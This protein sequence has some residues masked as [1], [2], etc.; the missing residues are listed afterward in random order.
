MATVTSVNS[1]S[2]GGGGLRGSLRY[3]SQDKKTLLEEKLK[4]VSGVNCSPDTAFTEFM[5]TKRSFGKTGG[6]Q[7]Y[8]FV[9]SFHPNESVTPE[10][11]HRIGLELAEKRFPGFEVVVATHMDTEYLHSHL[12]V[13]SVSYETGKKLHQSAEDLR[14]HRAVSDE[15]RLAHGL[16]ILPPTPTSGQSNG[17]QQREY[18][19]AVKGESWKFRLMNAIDYCMTRSR[20]RREFIENMRRMEYG[21][22]WSDTRKHIT[23]TC[24]SGMKCRDNRLHDTKYLKENMQNEFAYRQIERTEPSGITEAG[25]T[26]S[27]GGLCGSAGAMGGHDELAWEQPSPADGN[28]GG[29]TT[30]RQRTERQREIESDPI[31]AVGDGATG[32]EESRRELETSEGDGAGT[33]ETDGRHLLETPHLVDR[34]LHL[35]GDIAGLARNLG[36]MS[37]AP[38]AGPKPKTVHERKQAIGQKQDDHEQEQT[39]EMTM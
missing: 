34:G 16:S 22:S 3:I 26:L 5:T 25:Q 7:F 28:G 11:V 20:S 17:V 6:R 29:D 15:I 35:A 27:T 37:D 14:Q 36:E 24:P 18:R 21:V 13:N 19:A 33:A 4:L 23:Y 39:Y 8:H 31:G 12:I 38:V 32:W 10:Q 30:Q 9:Q 2:K 1:R